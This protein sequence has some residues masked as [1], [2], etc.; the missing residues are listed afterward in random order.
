MYLAIS[1]DQRVDLQN[2]KAVRTTT[3]AIWLRQT[4][5][6]YSLYMDDEAA[7]ELIAQLTALLEPPNPTAD[8]LYIDLET[9][10][11]RVESMDAPQSPLD[12]DSNEP[13]PR[14]YVF[15]ARDGKAWGHL[16]APR[17]RGPRKFAD[18]PFLSVDEA[19]DASM[20]FAFGPVVFEV[21]TPESGV[22]PMPEVTP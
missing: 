16:D 5:G 4:D 13:D 8:T 20:G 15:I 1:T 21:W 10:A 12:V 6:A 17:F 22:P 3:G 2:V 11:S 14:G 7:R 9:N 19:L 18:R